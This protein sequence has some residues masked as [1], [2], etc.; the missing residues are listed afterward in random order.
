MKREQVAAF[1]DWFRERGEEEFREY[2]R[3]KGL[4]I[5]PYVDGETAPGYHEADY[6][7]SIDINFYSLHKDHYERF[8]LKRAIRAAYKKDA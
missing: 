4:P 6:D 8:R 1:V 7:G 2:C 3:E 5:E